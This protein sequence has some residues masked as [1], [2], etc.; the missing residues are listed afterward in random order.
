MF[1][2]L[3]SSKIVDFNTLSDKINYTIFYQVMYILKNVPK[4]A[5]KFYNVEEFLQMY[6][7]VALNL[8]RPITIT[9]SS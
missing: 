6:D 9:M 5:M 4:S 1:V 8:V 2:S 3:S 7:L